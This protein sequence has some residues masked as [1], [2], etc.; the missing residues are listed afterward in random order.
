M[1]VY[2]SV[3]SFISPFFFR[4]VI[5]KSVM[6]SMTIRKTILLLDIAPTLRYNVGK[7]QEEQAPILLCQEIGHRF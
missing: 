6:S 7:A 4:I 2:L 3:V 1:V 5:V